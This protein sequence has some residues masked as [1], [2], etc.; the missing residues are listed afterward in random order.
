MCLLP[1]RLTQSFL[2][3]QKWLAFC[4]R[5][6]TAIL[7]AAKSLVILTA[8][9]GIYICRG[10]ALKVL[11]LH[12]SPSKSFPA[13]LQTFI[14]TDIFDCQ[15]GSIFLKLFFRII[16]SLPVWWLQVKRCFM[17][18][19]LCYDMILKL[20]DRAG[21]V[22]HCYFQHSLWYSTSCQCCRAEAN[23]SRMR[24]RGCFHDLWQA[25][26]CL[27]EGEAPTHLGFAAGWLWH[28]LIR[29]KRTGR[30]KDLS[31]DRHAS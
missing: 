20:W 27:K 6:V 24:C 30:W 17:R 5:N 2:L 31:T 19:S 26:R 12:T 11:V 8:F 16:C 21:A 10:A 1:G 22:T 23:E 9:R 15:W 29:S 7:Q 3:K 4:K 13:H 28:A 14:K 18:C 25:S